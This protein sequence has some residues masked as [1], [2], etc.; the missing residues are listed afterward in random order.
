LASFLSKNKK[1]LFFSGIIICSV[2]YYLASRPT[3][4][5]QIDNVINQGCE[6]VTFSKS[7]NPIELLGR[8]KSLL[9]L[10]TPDVVFRYERDELS[11]HQIS[12]GMTQ[13]RKVIEIIGEKKLLEHIAGGLAQMRTI[14]TKASDRT[15][16]V[17][18][19]LG[20]ANLTLTVEG[21]PKSASEKFYN[22]HEINL[23]FRKTDGD[24]KISEVQPVVVIQR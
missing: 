5:R 24:W 18:N 1:F 14:K 13:E 11:A 15:I 6:F 21:Q 9:K 16:K 19:E 3:D 4:E 7:E 20:T 12:K 2:I 8:A 22:A 17:D 23:K 10:F